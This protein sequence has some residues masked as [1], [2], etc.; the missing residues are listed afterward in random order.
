MNTFRDRNSHSIGAAFNS[1]LTIDYVLNKQKIV[2]IGKLP[3]IIQT[4]DFNIPEIV[5]QPGSSIEYNIQP[6]KVFWVWYE[7]KQRVVMESWLVKQGDGDC[8]VTY[9]ESSENCPEIR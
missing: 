1:Q 5:L 7:L 4:D 3:V 2:N 8:Q 9:W 6:I